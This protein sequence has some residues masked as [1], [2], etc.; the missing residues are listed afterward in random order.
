MCESILYGFGVKKPA[1]D[2]S[3]Y[4]C[5]LPYTKPIFLSC[6][7]DKYEV[8]VTFKMPPLGMRKLYLEERVDKSTIFKVTF[9]YF[10]RITNFVGD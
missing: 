6:V 7:R 3:N 4:N 1:L 2:S 5:C 10:Y 8:L 9:I